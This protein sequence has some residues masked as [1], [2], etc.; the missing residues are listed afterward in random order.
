[1]TLISCCPL[2]NYTVTFKSALFVR[3]FAIVLTF[4]HEAKT[5]SV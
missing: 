2:P 4:N 5:I 3:I 1:M